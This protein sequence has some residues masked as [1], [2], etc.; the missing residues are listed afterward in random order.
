MP[1]GIQDFV[2]QW[3]RQWLVAWQHQDIAWTNVDIHV[4]QMRVWWEILDLNGPSGDSGQQGQ[5]SPYKP[6]NP[7]LYIGIIIFSHIDNTQST[8]HN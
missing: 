6:C 4:S 5:Y 2:E 1:C 7:S 3:F 8:G